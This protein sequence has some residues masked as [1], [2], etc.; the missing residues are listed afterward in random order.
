MG[1]LID[2]LVLESL[3]ALSALFGFLG[4]WIVRDAAGRDA[5][6]PRR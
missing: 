6:A 1:R 2:L 5:G 3:Y 4:F